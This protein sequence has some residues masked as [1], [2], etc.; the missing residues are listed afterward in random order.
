MLARL[1]SIKIFV[2][3]RKLFLGGGCSILSNIDKVICDKGIWIDT[4][5]CNLDLLGD[6]ERNFGWKHESYHFW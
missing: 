2:H 4:Q 5:I 1:R 3:T 6:Q